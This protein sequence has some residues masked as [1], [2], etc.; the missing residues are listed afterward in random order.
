MFCTR[1]KSKTICEFYMLICTHNHI[2]MMSPNGR[3][4]VNS[5]QLKHLKKKEKK[6]KYWRPNGSTTFQSTSKSFSFMFVLNKTEKKTQIKLNSRAYTKGLW[7][8][9]YIEVPELIHILALW[10]TNK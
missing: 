1:L 5:I 6:F 7:L 8:L 3:T 10:N 2:L 9:E 4:R